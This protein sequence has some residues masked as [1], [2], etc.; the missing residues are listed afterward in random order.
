MHW[1][2]ANTKL[3]L[4]VAFQ[5]TGQILKAGWCSLS[6]IQHSVILLQY[7]LV[8][9]GIFKTNLSLLSETPLLQ[10]RGSFLIKSQLIT[11]YQLLS[12]FWLRSKKV[13]PLQV[14]SAYR[15]NIVHIISFSP[16]FVSR[17]DKGCCRKTSWLFELG[18][19]II[20]LPY[21]LWRCYLVLVWKLLCPGWCS[22]LPVPE[23]ENG[24]G[25]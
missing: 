18:G 23:W 15:A 7:C 16:K 13:F 21:L 19:F 11:S 3:L 4:L 12:C 9:A 22:S 24:H 5:G 14:Y 10:R 2:C 1:F 20:S 25:S 17:K 6:R 8:G